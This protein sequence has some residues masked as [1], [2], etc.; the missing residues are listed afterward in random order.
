MQISILFIWFHCDDIIN[1]S[2]S[3][4]I[5]SNIGQIIFGILSAASNGMYSMMILRFLTGFFLGMIHFFSAL[6]ALF[7]HVSMPI[8]VKHSS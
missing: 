8:E 7:D 4:V 3:A 5:S 1:V 6:I 2:F